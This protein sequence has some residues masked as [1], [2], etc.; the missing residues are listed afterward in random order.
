MLPQKL[1]S[2]ELE[3][4]KFV[5]GDNGTVHTTAREYSNRLEGKVNTKC[6]LYSRFHPDVYLG[7]W[8][9]SACVPGGLVRGPHAYLAGI[10]EF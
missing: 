7:T 2:S 8:Y 10:R 5:L 9:C 3:C 6:A 1:F 4:R